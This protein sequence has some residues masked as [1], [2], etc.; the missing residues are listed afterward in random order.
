MYCCFQF[1]W[2]HSISHSTLFFQHRYS[3]LSE[4]DGDFAT[5]VFI[6]VPTSVHED[7]GLSEAKSVF[8]SLG[9]TDVHPCG[10]LHI[11]LSPTV[12]LRFHFIN[13]VIE[14][15][16][17]AMKDVESFWVHVDDSYDMFA[18]ESGD[19]FFVALPLATSKATEVM[20][21]VR[22]V[23]EG[24]GLPAP[25]SKRPHISLAWTTTDVSEKL[26]EAIVSERGRCWTGIADFDGDVGI[27]VSEIV[28][29]AGKRETVIPLA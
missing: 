29:R 21:K 13:S 28:V 3:P 10:D 7:L 25:E 11:S 20:E 2:S 9:A 6:R 8:T 14:G 18:N 23:L 12:P 24:L 16:K 1:E 5:S 22:L 15:V 19:R 17:N 27:E 4:V 26:G